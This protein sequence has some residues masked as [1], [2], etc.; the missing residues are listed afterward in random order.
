MVSANTGPSLL[1]LDPRNSECEGKKIPSV[2]K[3][4]E[5]WSHPNLPQLPTGAYIYLETEA[6]CIQPRQ[7]DKNQPKEPSPA[8]RLDLSKG[9]EES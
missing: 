6:G 8:L 2:E 4:R 7:S 3:E 5:R 1:V 9:G